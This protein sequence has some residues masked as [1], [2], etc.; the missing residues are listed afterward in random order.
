MLAFSDE[1]LARVLIAGTAIEPQAQ[2]GWLEDIAKRLDKARLRST[3]PGAGYTRKWRERV[4][5]G[6]I[7]L[8]FEVDE[9]ET[10]VGLVE[11]GL[12]APLK[13]EDP[14]AINRAARK[15]LLTCLREGSLHRS[16][17]SDI[18]RA[19]LLAAA[20]K[21][22]HGRL[23]TTTGAGARPPEALRPGKGD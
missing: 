15:A 20:R 16:G 3:T 10:V 14:I 22:E 12:L 8:T 13:A 7:R 6:R 11:V 18:I 9:V 4:N 19:K 5:A 1:A 17:I 23:Q 21:Q 2:A